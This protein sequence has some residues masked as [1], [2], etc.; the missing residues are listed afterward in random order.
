MG[1]SPGF[2]TNF[3]V[4]F[5]QITYT[6][7]DLICSF[8]N[9]GHWIKSSLRYHPVLTI[10]NSDSAQKSLSFGSVPKEYW[11][12]MPINIGHV[13]QES[14][15]GEAVFSSDCGSKI[16]R[17][18]WCLHLPLIHLTKHLLTTYYIPD[19]VLV[20]FMCYHCILRACQRDHYSRNTL[21]IVQVKI[22]DQVV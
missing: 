18:H 12:F 19:P 4:V 20:T 17:R 21:R 5:G 22:Y 8:V 14:R 15:P 3:S 16:H 1:S 6:L 13:I 10:H 11:A 7:W 2:V 9:L